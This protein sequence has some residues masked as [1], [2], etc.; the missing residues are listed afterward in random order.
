MLY[1]QMGHLFLN[2][3]CFQALKWTA[4]QKQ[5]PTWPLNMNIFFQKHMEMS[6]SVNNSLQIHPSIR[7]ASQKGKRK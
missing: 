3:S 1:A 7:E 5:N 4:A 2:F 6:K